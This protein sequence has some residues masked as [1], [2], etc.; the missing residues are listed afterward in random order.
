MVNISAYRSLIS[1]LNEKDVRLVAVSKLKTPEDIQAIYREGH[2]CFGE[3]YVQE[4]VEKQR[5]LPEDIQWHFIGHLQTN[6]VRYIAPFVSMIQSVDSFKLLMEVQKQA[7]K[8]NRVIDVLVQVYVGDE[9]TKYG[10]DEKETLELLEYYDAQKANF[11]HVQIRGLMGMASF[12][13]DM[14]VVRREFDR[15]RQLFQVLRAQF[16]IG[17]DTFDTLS[18]GMS[19]DYALAIG[20][21][22][23]MV[24]IGST[25]FGNR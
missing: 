1:E 18:M 23:N 24:R 25:I 9:D 3:N 19:S 7:A 8:N 4:M 21:G 13:N 20:E 17:I 10:M 6:K 22:S 11:T 5:Q 2:R 14:G 16:F 12:V 15:M